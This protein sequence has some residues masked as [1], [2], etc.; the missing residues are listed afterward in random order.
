[1]KNPRKA[2][3]IYF[4]QQW[5]SNLTIDILCS[6]IKI[7]NANSVLT[8]L[9]KYDYGCLLSERRV[10]LFKD[11]FHLFVILEF[12]TTTQSNKHTVIKHDI[13]WKQQ[14]HVLSHFHLI[15]L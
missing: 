2:A 7:F 11:H 5:K 9:N 13:G 12:Q 10:C 14:I 3:A 1:M 8:L 15:P 4:E 6:Q